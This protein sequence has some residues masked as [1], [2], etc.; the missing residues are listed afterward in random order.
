MSGRV[1]GIPQRLSARCEMGR[2]MGPK[3]R[4]NF[5]PG[6]ALVAEVLVRGAN[7]RHRDS[8]G[9]DD[10]ID[11]IYRVLPP[12]PLKLP[13]IASCPVRSRSKPSI[14]MLFPGLALSNL[15]TRAVPPCQRNEEERQPL[16][17]TVFACSQCSVMSLNP[18]QF[19]A[20]STAAPK[21]EFPPIVTPLRRRK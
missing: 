13:P 2:F 3:K 8:G 5:Y 10:V 17:D 4:Q 14:L 6:D 16:R 20:F 7:Y 12:L 21:V 18:T 9:Y 11:F 19:N 1:I 15:R